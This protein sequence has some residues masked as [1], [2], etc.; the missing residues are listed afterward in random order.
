MGR[1][2]HDSGN[3]IAV[4]GAGSFGTAVA[5]TLARSGHAVDLYCRTAEQ[6]ELIQDTRENRR[7]FPGHKLQAQITATNDL[8]R[9]LAANVIFLA[10]PARMMDDYAGKIAA[11][12]PSDAIVVNLVKGLHE[13]AFT[14]AA[15]FERVKPSVRYVSLKGPTFARPLFLGEWSGLTC[16]TS[17]E[18]ARALV[19][20]LFK[21]API[22]LDYSASAEAVDAVSAAKNVYAIVLGLAASVGLSENTTYL[23]V[24][25]ILKEISVIVRR[26]GFDP[27]VLLSFAGVGDTLLT[28]LCDTSRNRTLGVM[29]GRGIPID[30]SR[31]DFLAEGA[32]AV[33]TLRRHLEGAETP[34]LD[35]VLAIL[36]HRAE[37]MSILN[38]FEARNA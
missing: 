8:D 35:A 36:E 10:F 16:G 22:V 30:S 27:A 6:A 26:L 2:L 29:M 19:T 1:E 24:T 18:P 14:F 20:D 7:Y 4:L 34:L 13:E 38:V 11:G 32:R 37:P 15:L 17:S 12:A 21:D 28:G 9:A 5:A 31:S 23:F 3:H 25:L 33:S